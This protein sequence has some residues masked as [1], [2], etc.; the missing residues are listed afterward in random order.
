MKAIPTACWVG[1]VL[2]GLALPGVARESRLSQRHSSP[3][4]T[5]SAALAD[6]AGLPDSVSTIQAD[7]DE[8]RRYQEVKAKA[9]NDPELRKLKLKSDTAVT[10]TDARES[11]IAYNRALFRKIA[12]LDPALK[13]RAESVQNA[14][15]RMIGG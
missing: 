13:E 11:L 3:A 8:E 6:T 5:A 15:L 12:Q 14:I 10:E 2:C 9:A 1:A 4:K 7:L